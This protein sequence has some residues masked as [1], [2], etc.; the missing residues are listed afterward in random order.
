M[1][2]DAAFRFALALFVAVPVTVGILLVMVR[3]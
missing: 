1:I 2:V 3:R